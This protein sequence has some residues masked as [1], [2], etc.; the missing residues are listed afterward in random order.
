M[1]ACLSRVEHSCFVVRARDRVGIAWVNNNTEESFDDPSGSQTVE[2]EVL[3]HLPP[4]L[5]SNYGDP[6]FL[7]SYRVRLAC[8]SGAMANGIAS[9]ELV[10][11]MGSRGLLASFGSAGLQPSRVE[12]AIA[13]IQAHLPEG[14]YAFN[15]INDPNNPCLEREVVKIYLK[16]NVRTIEASAF[17]DLTLPLVYFRTCGLKLGPDQRP[18]VENRIIAKV[19]RKEVALKF[20]EPPPPRL[21]QELRQ[22]SLID[23][24]Q[25]KLAERV[26]M[27]DDITVEA[28]SGGHTD[29]RPL[30]SL[31]PS[32][33]TLRDEIQIKRGYGQRVRIGAAGG[34]STPESALAC[35]DMGAAYV[36][37]GSVNQSCVEAAVSDDVKKLLSQAEMT[38]V[39][40]APS[41]D[42]FEAGVKVQVLKKGTFFPM[43]AQKLYELYRQYDS[44]EDIPVDERSRLE[45][46]VFKRSIEAVWDET[47]EYFR[48]IDPEKI[49]LAQNDPKIRM[50][51]IF[52]W[53]LG[54]S[55]KW[56]RT[57]E[58]SRNLDYQVWCGPSMG[59]F[60]D[61]VRGTYLEEPKNRYVWD[62]VEQIMWGVGYLFR[63]RLL[64]MHGFLVSPGLERFRLRSSNPLRYA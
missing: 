59:A 37:T 58:K 43:R 11:A 26:P 30:V 42:M 24:T 53:Y 61:W 9:E 57:G 18:R 49:D 55:S 10:C 62:I 56:A 46:T 29:N 2:A 47:V 16:R 22:S 17:M 4:M 45:K 19:S 36:V 35:F 27:A 31:L 51:L 60:N 28:D 44:V 33:I 25:I 8:C 20:L 12:D 3:M 64:R 13:K 34:V 7:T 5:P 63:I 23:E 41:A 39:T 48:R 40:M 1:R 32:L 21:L 50:G 52:R 38:D 6:T 14:P 54:L 15:L